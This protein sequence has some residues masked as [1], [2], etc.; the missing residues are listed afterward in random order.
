METKKNQ[1]SKDAMDEANVYLK[2]RRN[3][4]DDNEETEINMV[5]NDNVDMDELDEFLSQFE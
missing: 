3:N 4:N 5:D 1:D 2:Y